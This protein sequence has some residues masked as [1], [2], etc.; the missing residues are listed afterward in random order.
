MHIRTK[1]EGGKVIN[2]SQSGSWE[3]RCAGAGLRANKGPEW[4]PR[5]W[6]RI[7]GKAANDVFVRTAEEKAHQVED[8]KRKTTDE[9]KASRRAFKYAKT[10]DDSLQVRSDYA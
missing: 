1:F 2:R 7:T 6:K 5:T 9:V 10:N 3:V 4:G 8:R